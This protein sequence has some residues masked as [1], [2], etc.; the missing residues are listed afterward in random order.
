MAV[1]FDIF[2][3]KVRNSGF[4]MR[5]PVDQPFAAINQPLLVHINKDFQH[6][7][8]KVGAV[9]MA[10]ARITGRAGHGKGIARPVARRAKA[11][12]L[13]YNGAA[14]FAFPFPDFFKEFFAPQIAAANITLLSEHFFHLQLGGNAGMVLTGLPQRIKAAHPVP[15]G[16]NILQSIVKG[17]ANMQ[18]AGDIGRR[19]HNAKCFRPRSVRAGFKTS[20]LFPRVVKPVF[21]ASCIKGFFQWHCWLT[22]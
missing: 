4:K 12:E 1:N 21:G 19:D 15:T 7:V 6:R 22:R 20:G 14:V 11:F 18:R 16:Q 17:M 2:H 9:F 10:N 8:M 3:F 5:V 13:I